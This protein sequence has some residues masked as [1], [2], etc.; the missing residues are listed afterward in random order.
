MT[1]QMKGQFSL[2]SIAPIAIIPIALIIALLI[3]GATSDTLRSSDIFAASGGN[4]TMGVLGSSP[5]TFN[6]DNN[7]VDFDTFRA[8]KTYTD[9]GG[10][11]YEE[12]FLNGSADCSNDCFTIERDG[13][14]SDSATA[15]VLVYTDPS[16]ASY[17][18]NATY[19]YYE[20]TSAS[21]SLTT[22]ETNS[23]SGFDLAGILPIVIA[24]VIIIGVVLGAVAFRRQ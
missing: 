3:F 24:G 13:S 19:T 4:E 22:V 8:W 10:G 18:I 20:G 21:Q 11:T 15:E 23:A 1:T 9:T 14:G 17:V 2:A 6:T 16:N 12:I 5:S 7:Y